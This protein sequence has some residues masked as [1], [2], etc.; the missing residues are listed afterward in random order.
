MRTPETTH[1][2]MSSIKSKDTQPELMLRKALWQKNMRYR[3]NY[4][5]LPGTP[6]IVFTKVKVV[7]FCDGDFWHGHN[8]VI[9]GMKSL[10]DELSSYSEFWKK[11]ILRNIERDDE[12]TKK[13][14]EMGWK[15]IRIW[16]SEIKKDVDKC[17]KEIEAVIFE[18]KMENK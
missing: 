10:E 16:E 12:I 5:N 6:D 13:L 9:R 2:I 17:V 1:K 11:K 4:K 3:V 8:W 18:N 15:V 14:N 7:V